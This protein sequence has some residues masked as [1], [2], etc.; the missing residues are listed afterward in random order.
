M[1]RSGNLPLL[2]VAGSRASRRKATAASTR[3]RLRII[4]SSFEI[5]ML[6]HLAPY[7]LYQVIQQEQPKIQNNIKDVI[8]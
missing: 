4:G 3:D 8:E 2:C 1:S 6:Y 7:D 5:T